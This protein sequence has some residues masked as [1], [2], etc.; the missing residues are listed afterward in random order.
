MRNPDSI[1]LRTCRSRIPARLAWLILSLLSGPATATDVLVF[2]A[3]SLKPSL[4][5]ILATAAARQIGE[6]SVSYAASSQLARQIDHAAPA[7]MFIS[8]DPDWMDQVERGGHIIPGTRSNLLGNALVL[9]AP[10]ASTLELQI[11]PDFEL[12]AALGTDGRLAMGEPGSVPAGRYARAALE[13]LGVWDKV[14]DRIVP[15]L[16]VRAALNFVVRNEAPLGIVYRSDAVSEHRVRVVDTFAGST[17]PPIIYP[18]A[19]LTGGDSDA[20][21]RLLVLLH[22]PQAATIFSR[23]GFDLP[24]P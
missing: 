1:S 20:A 15:A 16:H 14:E 23:S 10:R 9:I 3:A 7:S 4:D 11:K 18:V 22:S 6:V 12:A 5:A 21:R 17:H 8:A 24:E 19:L 2:A 13:S